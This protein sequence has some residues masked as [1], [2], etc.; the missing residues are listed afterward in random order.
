MDPKEFKAKAKTF[1]I[2]GYA[3]ESPEEKSAFDKQLTQAMTDTKHGSL[4]ADLATD[5]RDKSIASFL[6]ALDAAE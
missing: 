3:F 6:A 1:L 2:V 4:L 5:K